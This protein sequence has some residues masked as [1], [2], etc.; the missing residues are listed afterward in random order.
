MWLARH[1][2]SLA[3]LATAISHVA[4]QEQK[5]LTDAIASKPFFTVREQSSDLCDAGSRQWTG[6]VNVTADKSMF[7]WYFESRNKPQTDPL[8]LWMSGGPG[9]AGG[10]GLFVG[11]GPCVVN[12]D[13]NST[14]RSEYAWTDHANVV[15][16]DQPVGV[17]FSKITDRDDIAVSLEQGARDVHSF[18]SAFSQ[19]VFPEFA[20]RPW[21]IT[22]ESMGGHYVTGYTQHIASKEQDNARRGVEPRIN[23]SSAIIVD[24]YI[25]ATRQSIG[26]HDFFCKDW[27]KDGRKAPLM[28]D[29][30]CS[31]MAAAI[32]E[33]EKLAVRC[34]ESYDIPECK[35]ANEV[36]EETIGEYFLDGVTRGGWDPYDDRHP[37]EEPPMCSNLDHGPTWKF[38]NQRW[39]QQ[40][41]GFEKF[42]FDLID[43]DTNARWDQAENIHLPVTRELTWILDNTD[44]AVLFINGNDDI[45]I[46]TPGQMSML[47]NQPWEGQKLYRNLEYNDW[48]YKN[49]DLTSD[50]EGWGAKRGGFWKGN[51]R[52]AIYAVDEAGHLSPHHQPEAIGA[53]V[54]AWLRNY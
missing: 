15:Y 1:V 9:A 3:L 29:T 50:T 17:G 40:K 25:D 19:D 13:G 18:L 7:F 2:A 48:Y 24:G 47:D 38:L 34:R 8:L 31:T 30:A 35:A 53:I 5:P 21:H 32:P 28:N 10:M 52:L 4:C 20:G 14:R 49:G 44:I 51:D 27:A 42:P 43:L 11:S 41:L 46:N 33:C 16:I 23:I 36:C 39:V 6:T 26:Y 45:I 22:G 12:R 54:R 37:C